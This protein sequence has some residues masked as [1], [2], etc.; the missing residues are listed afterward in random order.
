MVQLTVNYFN[1]LVHKVQTR[2]LK[3]VLP[4]GPIR[5]NSNFAMSLTVQTV[6][7]QRNTRDSA[8]EGAVS[9]ARDEQV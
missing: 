5:A 9:R 1:Q 7:W 6:D 3:S 8:P 4:K 2:N